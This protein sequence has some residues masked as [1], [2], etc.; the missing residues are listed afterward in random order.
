MRA[1]DG[2]GPQTGLTDVVRERW[3]DLTQAYIA[4][5]AAPDRV[6]IVASFAAHV[7]RL[8]AE[9][10]EISGRITRAAARELALSVSTAL[11]RVAH[12]DDDRFAVCAMGGVFRS[13]L[14][15]EAFAAALGESVGDAEVSLDAPRGEGIDGAIALADLDSRHPLSS[16]VHTARTRVRDGRADAAAS[17]RP[18][19]S[20]GALGRQMPSMISLKV[21]DGR[22][23]A[24]TRSA[25]GR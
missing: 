8:A 11:D 5:Q 2:R 12:P 22:M 19:F 23:T 6:S 15:H 24:S 9:G 20:A 14:L 1:Y 10:D 25:S 18:S 17:A 13:P 3:P 21:F 16:A 4:L 7:A